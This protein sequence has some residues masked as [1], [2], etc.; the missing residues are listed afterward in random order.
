MDA[1]DYGWMGLAQDREVWRM[2]A[3]VQQ[4]EEIGTRKSLL[5]SEKSAK[6]NIIQILSYG[7][8]NFEVQARIRTLSN[9]EGKHLHTMKMKFRM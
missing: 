1:F 5:H 9:G 7:K 3:F 8:L 6:K 2:E 4:W